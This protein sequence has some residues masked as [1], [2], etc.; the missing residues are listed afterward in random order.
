MANEPDE[1]VYTLYD[2]LEDYKGYGGD[3]DDVKE[4]SGQRDRI[5]ALPESWIGN[6][7]LTFLL[8]ESSAELVPHVL[9]GKFK[10]LVVECWKAGVFGEGEEGVDY[11]L[12]AEGQ[13]VYW[14][15]DYSVYE[16]DDDDQS[17]EKTMQP[18]SMWV[19]HLK[20]D[21]LVHVDET[22]RIEIVNGVCE[23]ILGLPASWMGHQYICFQDPVA[24][25]L[26]NKWDEL[27]AACW[28]A[29]VFGEPDLD[30]DYVSD[31]EGNRTCRTGPVGGEC[32]P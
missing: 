4:V 25:V 10:F 13:R 8:D 9:A 11:E 12:N 21:D 15:G 7:Y 20:Q 26:W 14:D 27:C 32:G 19:H 29:G 18:L 5:L 2:C 23:Q 28:Q 6:Q 3:D 30:E 24:F 16:D 17:G 31:D 1:T 22:G